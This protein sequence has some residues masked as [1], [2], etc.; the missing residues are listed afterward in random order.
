MTLKSLFIPLVFTAALV[1]NAPVFAAT[2]TQTITLTRDLQIPGET[3]KPGAYTLAV[4][5]RM[6]DRAIVRLSSVGGGPHYLLLGVPN[7]EL[8]DRG[9]KGIIL[10]GAAD[11][12]KRILQGWLCPKCSSAL[13]LVYPKLEAVQITKDTGESAL[14]VDPVSDKLP[15]NLSPDDMKVVT[16]WLLSPERIVAGHRGEGLKAAKYSPAASLADSRHLPHTASNAY[17]FA[18]FGMLSLALSLVVRSSRR[19]SQCMR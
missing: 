10:F 6:Q 14:A 11:P 12:S 19:N 4:E 5:D 15:V 2:N 8:N 18:L 3:L 13:E 7:S 16:L 9:E 17:W 1:S